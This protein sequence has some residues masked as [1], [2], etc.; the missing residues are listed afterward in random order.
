[1]KFQ[2]TLLSEQSQTR[3][4]SK[5]CVYDLCVDFQDVTEFLIFI[6]TVIDQFKDICGQDD[7]H[8]FMQFEYLSIELY[9]SDVKIFLYL[10]GS[11]WQI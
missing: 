1:M 10:S 5:R 4:Y 7:D 6:S 11:L 9:S 8:K 2:A 3:F